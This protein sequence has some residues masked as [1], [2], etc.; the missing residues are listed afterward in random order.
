MLNYIRAELWKLRRRKYLWVLL[1]VML[2]LEGLFAVMSAWHRDFSDL[3]ELGAATM[4]LGLYL[5]I[6]L[7]DM[8]FSDQYKIGTLKNEISFGLPRRRIYLGKLCA[9][10]VTGLASC[11]LLLGFYLGA[12]WL[13]SGGAG[14]PAA[15]RASLAL[16]GWVVLAALPLWVGMLGLCVAVFFLVKSELAAAAA[17]FFSLNVVPTV[18]G[19]ASMIRGNPFSRLL[20]L[21]VSLMPVTPFSQLLVSQTAGFMLR[22]WAIG[23]GWLALSGAAGL[24][25]F[26]RR[27]IL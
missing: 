5:S 11:A 6:F 7:A 18:L 19:L 22:N 25:V 20:E 10:L 21:L 2:G 27:Q 9:A 8:V 1:A 16:L 4:L 26:R 14:D 3:V 23:L 15:I 24:G 17:L 12:A 13:A